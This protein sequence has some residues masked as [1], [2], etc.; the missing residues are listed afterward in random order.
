[1][2][3]V[4]TTPEKCFLSTLRRRNVFCPHY[5]GEM[6]SV[7]T[8]PDKCF[9][10]TLPRI[11]VFCPHYPGEMFSVHTT[12]EKFQRNNHRSFSICVWG[13]P[14]QGNHMIMATS[15]IWKSAIFKMFSVH[16][17][18]QSRRFTILLLWRAF[19][20]EERPYSWRIIVNGRPNRR[21]KAA[22]SNLFCVV[23]RGGGVSIVVNQGGTWT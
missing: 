21:N 4:H 15:S 10:S 20:F 11:N 6:F 18:T 16:T 7:D 5:P 3:S 1:M 9:L 22:F 12:P 14:G 13:K 2:F 8:T 17:K 23:S 19:S